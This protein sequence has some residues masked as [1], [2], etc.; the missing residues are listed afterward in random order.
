MF[1]VED[2]KCVIITLFKKSYLLTH[3]S[4]YMD[5]SSIMKCVIS[6]LIDELV[7]RVIQLQELY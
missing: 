6:S 5:N 7:V 1:L 4:Y 2:I 3:L